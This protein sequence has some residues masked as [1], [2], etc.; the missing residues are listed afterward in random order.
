[1]TFHVVSRN[2]GK[3]FWDLQ[4]GENRHV[5]AESSIP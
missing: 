1:V 3:Q 5:F 4:H 2:F